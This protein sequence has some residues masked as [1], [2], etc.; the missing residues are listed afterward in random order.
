M[1]KLLRNPW[2]RISAASQILVIIVLISALFYHMKHT[3]LYSPPL[4]FWSSRMLTY[5]N[6][7]HMDWQYYSESGYPHAEDTEIIYGP[8]ISVPK[9]DYTLRINYQCDAK[10]TFRVYAFEQ[11]DRIKAQE[12]EILLPNKQKGNYHYILNDDVEQ[13]EIRVCSNGLG[14]VD[15]YDITFASGYWEQT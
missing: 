10:Q 4:E 7:W 6:G 1:K 12:P 2:F 11:E 8:F 9:G 3:V 13:L 15:I 14:N 5:D